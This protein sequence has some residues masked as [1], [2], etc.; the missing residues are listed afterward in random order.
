MVL[1]ELVGAPAEGR[2][3]GYA[4]RAG[5]ADA[6]PS[7][8]VRMDS[9]AR[10]LQDVA[11]ADIV[12]AGV[13]DLS[14]W[15]VRRTS[16]KV[17]RFPRFGEQ[18]EARTWGSATGRLWAERRTTISGPD[19]SIEAVG[20]WVHLDPQTRRPV[21][22]P[23][24]VQRVYWPSAQ[25]RVVKARL[26]HASPAEDARRSPWR[27]RVT[28]LDLAEHVNNAAYWEILEERLDPDPVSLDAEIEFREPAQAGEVEV[29]EAGGQLWVAA[30][31]GEP[32]HA[33]IVIGRRDP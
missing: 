13:V 33:S 1:S 29:L 19:A 23:D 14:S 9:I 26:R 15:V 32:V 31:G 11:Y 20:L 22:P 18:V 6:A 10:W 3:F 12:D 5:L 8:R 28:D 16:I 17:E 27:F 25:G 2:V 21:P 4:L 24:A 7:G 30:P